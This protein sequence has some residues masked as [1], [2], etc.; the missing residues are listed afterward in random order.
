MRPRRAAVVGER[1]Q[2][3]IVALIVSGGVGCA[4]LMKR[5]FDPA[6]GVE[7]VPPMSPGSS[8]SPP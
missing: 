7:S 1:M 4:E 2:L 8:P 6:I 3:R 5:L